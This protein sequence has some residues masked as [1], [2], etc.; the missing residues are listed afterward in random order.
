[1]NG[2][3]GNCEQRDIVTLICQAGGK[4]IDLNLPQ[5]NSP[6]NNP[7]YVFDAPAEANSSVTSPEPVSGNNDDTWT[8]ESLKIGAKSCQV[9]QLGFI[10]R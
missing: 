7:F 3:L 8:Y 2:H 10:M 6:P 9:G 4:A 1:M 5:A